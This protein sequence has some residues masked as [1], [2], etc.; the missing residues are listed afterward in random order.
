[1]T[2]LLQRWFKLKEA[3]STPRR[4]FIGGITTFLTMS[5]V[6]FVIPGM[7]SDPAI[8]MPLGAL[9]TATI[10]SAIYGTLV[11]AVYG[12]VPFAMAPGMGLGAYFAYS[13]C[14]GSG[15]PWP[16]A[17]G[18]VFLSG[19]FFL[20]LGIL[21]IRRL[22]AAS[23]P[24]SLQL[25]TGAGIG[26]FILFIGLKNLGII[27]GHPV[28]LVAI[29]SLNPPLVL[30]LIGI[31]ICSVLEAR[32]VTGG[33]LIGILATTALGGL[34]GHVAKPDGILS[35]PPSIG[36]IFGK[37]DIRGALV[38]AMIGPI[39]AL[40]FVDMFDSIGTM[41]AC[42]KG[43][44]ILSK[45]PQMT[46]LNR[47]LKVDASATVLGAVLGVPTVTTYV[48][49]ASGIA[50]GARTGLASIITALCFVSALLF[51]PLIASVPS[52]ATAPVLV[53]TGVIM[54]KN[55]RHLDYTQLDEL[56]PAVLTMILMPLTYTISVGI[57]IG[58]ISWTLLK[59]LTGRIRE[60]TLG[61][62]ICTGLAAFA[63]TE[64]MLPGGIPLPGR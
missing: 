15:V 21:G 2:N 22:I 3:G 29:G 17:L 20:I 30:G 51:S 52:F 44:G 42:G 16:V 10:L 41:I 59:M 8:G 62:W 19:L 28:T 1:M 18:A 55:I 48:E 45:D 31:L 33:L 63:L 61:M 6:I 54:F 32:R 38:P 7:L 26:L 13:L 40:M 43:S 39:F 35:L 60:V 25:A 5:Y 27:V 34:M 11:V 49:C 23:I 4:E 36:P 46:K 47:A 12:R 9:I 24:E 56:I 37:L 53:I 64:M 14:L 57:A 50:A 58:F